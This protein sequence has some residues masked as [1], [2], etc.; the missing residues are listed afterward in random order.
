MP[1]GLRDLDR[2]VP[3]NFAEV[4]RAGGI[5]GLS[6][7]AGRGEGDYEKKVKS[8]RTLLGFAQFNLV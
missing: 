4:G 3:V 1:C 8:Q 2:S 6:P 7:D 5:K